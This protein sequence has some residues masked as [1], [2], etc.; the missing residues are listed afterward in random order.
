MAVPPSPTVAITPD[1]QEAYIKIQI[2]NASSSPATQG[3]QIY[4]RVD[5]TSS[6]ALWKIV[7]PNSIYNDHE[8][9]STVTY[10]YRVRA[11]NADGNS[12]YST[13]S[14]GKITT[15]DWRIKDLSVPTHNIKAFIDNDPLTIS[16][17]QYQGKFEA[18]GRAD[19]IVI[20]DQK[21]KLATFN[22]SM[23][24]L[25]YN[26]VDAFVRLLEKQKTLLL[27]SP[28]YKQWYFVFGD[29][30][31]EDVINTVDPYIRIDAPIIE[32]RRPHHE[33]I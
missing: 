19:P 28:I 1:N 32:V 4:R 12:S 10:Q 26:N 3:N 8:A 31:Q 21:V 9:A 2:T 14:S 15:N 22:I 11:F 23:Q 13:I 6:W 7:G 16:R 29:N 5:G 27:Q 33:D 20:T 24:I 25:G 17:K 30:I 18:I